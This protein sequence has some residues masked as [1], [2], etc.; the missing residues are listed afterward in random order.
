MSSTTSDALQLDALVLLSTLRTAAEVRHAFAER[1]AGRDPSEQE[2]IPSVL[3]SLHTTLPELRDFVTQLRLRLVVEQDDRVATLLAFEERTV[4]ARL[5]RELHVVHQRLLS[6]YPEVAE[7]LVEEARLR[8]HEAARLTT[9]SRRGFRTDL[10]RWL[11]RTTDFLE[12]LAE[13]APA[14][15]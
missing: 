5:A 12:A 6:L 2:E 15:N 11:D 14:A 8:Q 4:L 10:G 13:A 7:S 1:R 9:A 3:A